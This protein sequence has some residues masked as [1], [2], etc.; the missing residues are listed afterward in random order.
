MFSRFF[1]DRPKYVD[2]SPDGVKAAKRNKD[3]VQSKINIFF[4]K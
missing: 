2:V 1:R 3:P 4:K